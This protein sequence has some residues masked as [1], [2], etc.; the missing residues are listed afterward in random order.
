MT[1]EN[2]KRTDND[3]QNTTQKTKYRATRTSLKP[4]FTLRCSGRKTRYCSNSDTCRVILAT[5]P[6]I[7]HEGEKDRGVLTRSGIYSIYM[8][9]RFRYI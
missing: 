3:I 9:N 2:D 6:V 7:S 4:G 8:I 1:K 5:N